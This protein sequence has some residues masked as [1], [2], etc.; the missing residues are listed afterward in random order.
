MNLTQANYGYIEAIKHQGF[1]VLKSGFPEA[2]RK[3]I[4]DEINRIANEYPQPT[5]GTPYLNSQSS[6]V[7]NPDHKSVPILHFILRSSRNVNF[8]MQYFLN[9]PWYRNIPPSLPNYI[10]RASIARSSNT[11][12]LP[13]HIDSF[14]PSSGSHVAVMQVLYALES[15]TVNN[16]CTIVIPKSHLSDKYASQDAI[17][18]ATPLELNAGDIAIW[19]SRLWHGALPN[20]SSDSRWSLVATFTRWWIKQN[21]QKP[22]AIP[23]SFVDT[24]QEH[25]KT[26]VGLHSYPPYD[27]YERIDIKGGYSV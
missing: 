24:L 15:S 25:E 16:G 26:I 12:P 17:S 19:D 13:L 22:L 23:H 18:E 21:Y 9:D 6:L 20:L 14:I 1:T 11:E 3:L 4:L 27:E 10:L 5:K 8:I 7:Y 2:S